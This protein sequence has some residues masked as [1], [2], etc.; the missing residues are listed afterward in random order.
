MVVLR[1]LATSFLFLRAS[2]GETTAPDYT[3]PTFR[4]V[5]LLRPSVETRNAVALALG[6]LGALAV[7]DVPGYAAARD[8]SLKQLPECMDENPEESR[9]FTLTSSGQTRRTIATTADSKESSPCHGGL[10]PLR[11]ALD[12]TVAQLLSTLDLSAEKQAK[13]EPYEGLQDIVAGGTELEHFH[14]YDVP[15]QGE[16]IASKTTMPFHT[17]DG[18]MIAMTVGLYTDAS[19]VEIPAP[20]KAGLF[21]KLPH[22]A[23]VRAAVPEHDV[24]VLAGAGG[25]HWL[26]DGPPLRACP[27]ALEVGSLSEPGAHRSW[28]GRMLLPADDA[29]MPWGATFSEYRKKAARESENEHS[30]EHSNELVL[31]LEPKL[32]VSAGDMCTKDGEPGIF[33]WMKRECYPTSDLSCTRYYAGCFDPVTDTF[34]SP[35]VMCTQCEPRCQT[36]PMNNTGGYCQGGGIDMYMTGFAVQGQGDTLCLTL[37]FTPWLLDTPAKFIGGAIFV[38]F[39]GIFTELVSY[40]RREMHGSLDKGRKR[41]FLMISVYALHLALGY[42]CMLIAMTYS[43]ELFICILLGLAIGHAA[44]NLAQPPAASVEPCC[45][46]QEDVRNGVAEKGQTWDKGSFCCCVPTPR[47]PTLVPTISDQPG[48]HLGANVPLLNGEQDVLEVR[49]RPSGGSCCGGNMKPK[50]LPDDS[51]L[52]TIADPP[53]K[54][55]ESSCC[56]TKGKGSHDS[57]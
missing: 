39:L 26:A 2:H 17:D 50:F 18:L 9:E 57:V 35:A 12:T 42:W 41:D 46:S 16:E 4:F 19:G 5:D 48:H 10:S 7:T 52:Q 47:K 53:N 1:S 20:P 43:V 33:C 37:L 8:F 15:V 29:K 38:V 3:L 14:A 22:G 11:T 30:S 51:E 25:Q 32:G 36:E 55:A 56:K 45:Q 54:A 34:V 6:S 31:A 24:V 23:V 40:C 49:P 28:H 44:F 21:I 13:L 27:H